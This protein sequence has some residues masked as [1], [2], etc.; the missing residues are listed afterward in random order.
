MSKNKMKN[1]AHNRKDITGQK[2][3]RLTALYPDGYNSD[4][5][6][7]WVCKCDCG[8]IVRASGKNLRS[9][10]TRSCGCLQKDITAKRNYKH[11]GAVRYHKDRL[12][13]IHHDMIR[14]CYDPRRKNY[15]N[16]GGRGIRVCDEWYTPED[17]SIGYMR[18]RKW[19]Y[20]NGYYDQPKDTPKTL[21]LSIDR[22]DNDGPYAPWNCKWQN[23]YGQSNN[24]GDFNQ[25]IQVDDKV[26][27]FGEF[28]RKF[29]LH[30]GAVINFYKSGW[31]TDQIIAK[32]LFPELG[33]HHTCKKG[34]E[35]FNI[36]KDGFI[37]L[38]RK[39]DQSKARNKYGK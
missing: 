24:R 39:T 11:G 12:Y 22:I 8:N 20:T 34:K 27:T 21:M 6:I 7:M 25:F 17:N 37:R 31:T 5:R 2:F 13:G 23:M 33:L 28:E 30:K 32:V 15:L 29:G 38:T 16:Y 26:Y 14:R 1:A 10:N 36:D 9:G 35:G 3:G 4:K 18:F 19:A